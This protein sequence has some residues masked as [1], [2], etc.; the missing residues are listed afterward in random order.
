MINFL[1]NDE[2]D[3]DFILVVPLHAIL[4]NIL[5]GILGPVILV[6]FDVLLVLLLSYFTTRV[7]F[8]Q[9]SYVI[10]IFGDAEKGIYPK[11]DPDKQPL[12]NE[13]DLIMNNVLHLF[14]NT[15]FLNSQLEEQK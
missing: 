3:L 7:N 4:Q 2:Y 15:T 12:N 9:I 11:A 13:Y 1:H 6:A 14:L 5:R 8:R 10:R